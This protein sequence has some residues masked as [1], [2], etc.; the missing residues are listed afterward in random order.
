MQTYYFRFHAYNTP[1]SSSTSNSLYMTRL[2][3]ST[4]VPSH[5][6]PGSSSP[7]VTITP[8][9]LSAAP[10][11]TRDIIYGDKTLSW[12]HAV[13]TLRWWARQC[14][15]RYT[16]E[17]RRGGRPT[18][19]YCNTL[20]AN[21][22]RKSPIGSVANIQ[23]SRPL[24]RTARIRRRLSIHT[25]RISAWIERWRHQSEECS[26]TRISH[27]KRYVLSNEPWMFQVTS[28]Q[29]RQVVLLKTIIQKPF[30]LNVIYIYAQK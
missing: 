19:R 11:I 3:A 30:A 2:S 29:D 24:R 8:V 7:Y 17:I 14:Y 26:D 13:Y 1:I 27:C 28:I 6:P 4:A 18:G 25:N 9:A 22:D 20:Q 5:S 15:S 10:P 12:S 21:P 16:Q 23:N